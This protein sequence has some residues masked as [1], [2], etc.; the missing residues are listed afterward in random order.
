M[1]TRIGTH[2]I[3]FLLHPDALS[4]G[5][6]VG[7]VSKL[8][9]NHI[10]AVTGGVPGH[11]WSSLLLTP[12]STQSGLGRAGTGLTPSEFQVAVK[13]GVFLGLFVNQIPLN[14]TKTRS[15][16]LSQRS[17]CFI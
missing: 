3:N 5:P 14:G 12:H 4:L 1:P 17:N 13:A 2:G 10:H 6:L 11:I 15:H 8:P 7:G 9:S 16:K